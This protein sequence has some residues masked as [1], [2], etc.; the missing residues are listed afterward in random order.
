MG[1]LGNIILFIAGFILIATSIKDFD[2]AKSWLELFK[3]IFWLFVGLIAFLSAVDNL[4][5]TE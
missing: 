3:A 1:K 2:D 4:K 5:D